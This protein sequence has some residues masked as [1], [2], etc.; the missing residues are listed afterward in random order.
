MQTAARQRPVTFAAPSAG[1]SRST[2]RPPLRRQPQ[3]AS[4]TNEPVLGASVA[5]PT[6]VTAAG[7]EGAAAVDEGRGHV[8]PSMADLAIGRG[9]AEKKS[10]QEVFFFSTATLVTPPPRIQK[11]LPAG[12]FFYPNLPLS[13]LGPQTPPP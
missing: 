5:G 9:R 2:S 12:D 7:A 10:P 1:A 11:F 13:P 3:M 6:M 4:V 8:G